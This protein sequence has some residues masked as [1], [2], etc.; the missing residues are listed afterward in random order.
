M[1]Q[2]RAQKLTTKFLLH[3]SFLLAEKK[4]EILAQK[5]SLNG[6]SISFDHNFWRQRWPK[7]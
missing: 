3:L 1:M 5:P 7:K 6:L 2:H 4:I